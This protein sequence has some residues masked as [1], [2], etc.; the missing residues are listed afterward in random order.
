MVTVEPVVS[1]IV[2]H[3]VT[4]NK[5]EALEP[6]QATCAA[7][8]VVSMVTAEWATI[9]SFRPDVSPSV[10]VKS[11]LVNPFLSASLYVAVA[12]VYVVG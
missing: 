9:A 8:P 12:S 5:V 4:S 7:V 10:T 3:V 1:A 2:V 11:V 6:H